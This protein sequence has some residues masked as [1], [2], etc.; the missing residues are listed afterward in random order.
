MNRV[1]VISQC[2]TM[3]LIALSAALA[4]TGFGPVSA[5]GNYSVV[6]LVVD[7]FGDVDL[8]TLDPWSVRRDGLLHHQPGR[9]GLRGARRLSDAPD[10]VAR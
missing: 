7:D 3:L 6:I 9:A 10:A 1:R 5:Q 4:V 2:R 8:A